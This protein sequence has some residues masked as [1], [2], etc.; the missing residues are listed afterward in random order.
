MGAET[1]IVVA[2]VL[3][4]L[5]MLARWFLSLSWLARLAVFVAAGWLASRWVSTG[6]SLGGEW[7]LGW[8]PHWAVPPLGA[9][10]LLCVLGYLT[11]GPRVDYTQKRQP[12]ETGTSSKS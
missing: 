11:R 8:F 12:E 10:I 9:L 3:I 6:H 7:S 4:G 1:L 2:A 5:W